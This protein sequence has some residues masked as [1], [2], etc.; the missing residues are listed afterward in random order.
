MAGPPFVLEFDMAGRSGSFPLLQRCA[1]IVQGQR[2][3]SQPNRKTAD[4]S[5]TKY[6]ESSLTENGR[7]KR[8]QTPFLIFHRVSPAL[9][10]F[11]KKKSDA[12]DR[13][14]FFFKWR[15]TSCSSL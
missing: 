7:R 6:H 11:S 1:S 3:K 5:E 12:K 2:L 15:R 9:T 4:S 13:V 14:F 8:Q 10:N